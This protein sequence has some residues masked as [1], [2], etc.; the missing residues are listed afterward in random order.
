MRTK[1]KKSRGPKELRKGREGRFLDSVDEC[2]V[3]SSPGTGPSGGWGSKLG[4]KRDTTISSISR[5]L[6][7]LHT[8]TLVMSW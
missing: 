6:E 5:L 8:V 2:R 7:S 1:V 3:L 4:F